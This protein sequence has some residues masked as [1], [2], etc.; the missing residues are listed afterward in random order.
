V[1]Q[2][3]I[4]GKSIRKSS[5]LKELKINLEYGKQFQT[6]LV[7]LHLLLLFICLFV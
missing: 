7:C 1:E 6:D 2:A 5:T 4:L 3:Q